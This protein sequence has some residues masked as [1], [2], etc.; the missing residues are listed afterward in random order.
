MVQP[1]EP[2]SQQERHW[3]NCQRDLHTTCQQHLGCCAEEWWTTDV[4]RNVPICPIWV[5]IPCGTVGYNGLQ[6]LTLFWFLN[7][8]PP[9]C[10]IKSLPKYNLTNIELLIKLLL[11]IIQ[12]HYYCC[13]RKL[14]W[15]SR[16]GWIK[17]V[18]S[19]YGTFRHLNHI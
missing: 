17:M 8:E 3:T 11:S 10:E 13:Y 16:V 4:S 18:S 14:T 5:Y 2:Q 19:D 1:E 7:F 9:C 12:S 6:E 15:I